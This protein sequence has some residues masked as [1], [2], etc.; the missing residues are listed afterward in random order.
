MNLPVQTPVPESP[1]QR[2]RRHTP[3][4][5]ALGR[6]GGS[7]PTN[8]LMEFRLAHA[9][10]R[11]A[12][13]RPLDE[14][15]LAIALAAASGG[16]I[17]RLQSAAPDLDQYLLRPDLGRRLSPKSVETLA[18]RPVSNPDLVIIIS[19][20]L[21]TLAAETHAAALVALLLPRL[22]SEGWQVAPI[23]L[24]RR[25]RVGLQDHLG[26][27]MQANLA[28]ILLGERPGLISPD[29]LGAY[30]VHHPRTGNTDARRNCVSNI[31]H[32]GLTPVDA[33]HK[34]HWLLTQSRQRS[35]SGIDLK[36]EYTAQ[37]PS[38]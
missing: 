26:E 22:Q 33:A 38:L 2:L 6:A 24:V 29:S 10:A 18:Q 28:L 8:A 23:C 35:L 17:L 19:E 31:S 25:A 9:Q 1:W 36:D 13:L 14:Q 7:L 20:G 15:S 5:V 4:R 16:P 34:L 37:L 32:Q 27:L 12:L 30:L 11:D 21:S 3:A